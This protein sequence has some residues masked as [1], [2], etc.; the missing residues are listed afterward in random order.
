MFYITMYV[1]SKYTTGYNINI[2]CFLI[3]Y[4]LLIL[5]FEY[6]YPII[7]RGGT[8]VILIY[9][10]SMHNIHVTLIKNLPIYT[11]FLQSDLNFFF[12]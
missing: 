1:H 6:K 12:F 10:I 9:F 3:N 7:Y 4:V 5:C 11:L 8:V 2:L